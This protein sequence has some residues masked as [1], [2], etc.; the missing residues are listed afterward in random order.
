M[1]KTVHIALVGVANHGHT[2]LTAINKAPNL[3]LVAC[4]DINPEA[5]AACAANHGCTAHSSYEALLADPQ[6]EAVALVTPN[7]LHA[8]Q[9]EA[10]FAAGKHVF[11]D[12]PITNTVTEGKRAV[13]QATQAGKILYVGHNT[14]KRR[15]FRRSKQLIDQGDIGTVV[16]I[17]ANL[18][19]IVGL[20]PEMPAWKADR[21]NAPILPMTQLGIH[22][23]DAAT[24]LLAPVKRVACLARTAALQGTAYDTT[25]A[26][27]ELEN[28]VPVSLNSYYVTPDTYFFRIYGTTGVIECSPREVTVRRVGQPSHTEDLGDE[29]YESYTL[30]MEE[31][32]RAILEGVRPETGGPEGL[33]NIAVMDAMILSIESGKMISID[34]ILK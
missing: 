23:V 31:F 19:R 2:I 17:E 15:V 9:I 24:Y 32:G 8:A 5:N 4:Y 29:G 7:H 27:L 20:T 3:T 18:S 26:L 11:V 28:G 16:A 6:V 33:H 14:R 21:K 13:A 34:D 1:S 10:A 25:T 22:F 12:K 30:Q